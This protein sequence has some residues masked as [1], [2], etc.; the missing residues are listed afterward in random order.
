MNGSRRAF[1][2]R[3]WLTFPRFALAAALVVIAGAAGV[4]LA[5]RGSPGPQRAQTISSVLRAPDAVMLTARIST[6][7][8]ATVV[9]SHHD[10]MGVFMA[11]DLPSLPAARR[12]ELWLMGPRGARPAGMLRTRPG[13]MAGPAL[14]VRMRPGDK[15]GLTIEPASGSPRP[16]SAT[17]VLI[18]PNSRS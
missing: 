11:H 4:I 13:G 9:L 7:G 16:T 12:Y 6:G 17:L 2:A 18:G 14:L 1:H 15:I 5:E 10:H 3:S 8:M